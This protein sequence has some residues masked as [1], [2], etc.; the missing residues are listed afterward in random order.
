MGSKNQLTAKPQ[1][2]AI[3]VGLITY[4]QPEAKALEYLAE[5]DFLA[6]TSDAIVVK[7]FTQRLEKPDGRTFVGK[8]KLEEIARY[9][10][11][12]EIDIIV[13][14]DELTPTQLRNIEE[15]VQCKILDRTNLIL[16]IFAYRARTAYARTQV[17]L[18]QYEYLLPRLTRMWTHLSK[19][20]GGIGMKGPGEKEIETDRRIIRKRI[21]LLKEELKDIDKQKQ[22]QRKQREK[23]IRVSLVGYT[24]V[25]KSTIMNVL[26]KSEVFAENKLFATLDTTV[27]KVTYNYLAFLLSDTVGF[28]RKLPHHLVES[29]KSTLDE[30]RESDLLLH[31]V[32]VSHPNYEEQMETVSKT[33]LEIGAGDKPV[34]IVFNKID[35]YK[36]EENFLEEETDK[37]QQQLL[38]ESIVGRIQTPAI[39]ISAK[40]GTNIDKLK[41][42]LFEQVKDLHSGKYPGTVP[43]Y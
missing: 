42:L 30:I 25:G 6:H 7:H 5:L 12:H 32:D 41:E 39:F 40:K 15:V 27:R 13:F 16:D 9:V 18:A 35:L 10:E 23:L 37:T 24:N 4:E 22:T 19:Q 28:I 43:F 33:L 2:R 31:I 36:H 20:R 1:E 11:E 29:F 38:E 3:L 21:S 34:V 14:D 8:G 26:S 17:E